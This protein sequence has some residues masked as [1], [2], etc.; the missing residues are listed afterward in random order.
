LFR[1][2]KTPPC[3]DRRSLLR[4]AAFGSKRIGSHPIGPEGAINGGTSANLRSGIGAI[5]AF[6]PDDLQ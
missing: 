2:V 1:F 4:I 3:L 5:Q 6:G